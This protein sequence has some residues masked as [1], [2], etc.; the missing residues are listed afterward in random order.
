MATQSIRQAVPLPQVVPFPEKPQITQ[1]QLVRVISI[2]NMIESLKGDLE[3]VETQVK[4]GLEAG[5]PVEP[6]THI[7]RLKECFRRSVAWRE[8]AE[9]L[10]ERLYGE[11]RGSAY[12]ANVLQNTKPD[13][14][15]NL[16][17]S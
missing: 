13:R 16:V 9:R 6:G 5:V 2:R 10:A 11:G 17:V 15:V 3:V 8:I 14:S 4:A 7:A 12:A 1:V